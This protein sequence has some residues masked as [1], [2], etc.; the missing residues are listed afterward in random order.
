[1]LKATL[2]V[3]V[4]WQIPIF[5]CPFIRNDSTWCSWICH[6]WFEW[7]RGEGRLLADGN[8]QH[9][10]PAQRK[11]SISDGCWVSLPVLNKLTKALIIFRVLKSDRITYYYPHFVQVCCGFGGVRCSGLRYVRLCISHSHCSELSW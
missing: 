7:R 1:M 11:A 4:E 5:L 3:R 6:W 10:P 2:T 8:T 9:W